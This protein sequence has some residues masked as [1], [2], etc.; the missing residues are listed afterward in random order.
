[1][2]YPELMAEIMK[3]NGLKPHEAKAIVGSVFEVIKRTLARGDMVRIDGFGTFLLRET[4]KRTNRN[5]QTGEETTVPE[6]VTPAFRADK[7]L[8]DIVSQQGK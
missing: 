6:S 4:G 1:M 5:S 7:E 8:M 3:D 2:T